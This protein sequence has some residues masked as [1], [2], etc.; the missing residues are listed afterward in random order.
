[1]DKKDKKEVKTI[2]IQLSTLVIVLI[3]FAVMII[4]LLIIAKEYHA[5]KSKQL[6]QN[7]AGIHQYIDKK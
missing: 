3:V 1:M 4:S 6:K 7:N 5:L 2:K